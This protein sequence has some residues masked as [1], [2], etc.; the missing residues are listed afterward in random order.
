MYVLLAPSSRFS[1]GADKKQRRYIQ[2]GDEV[3]K[4]IKE[5][6]DSCKAMVC[7]STIDFSVHTHICVLINLDL[8]NPPSET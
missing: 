6:T 5:E 1:T 7:G 8:R 2:S 4:E 3:L